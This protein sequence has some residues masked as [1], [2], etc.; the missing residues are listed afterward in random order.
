VANIRKRL[1]DLETRLTDASGFV[2]HSEQWLNYWREILLEGRSGDRT[3]NLPRLPIDAF[4]AIVLGTGPE[5]S[6]TR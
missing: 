3:T 2:P 5:R 4:R 1:Q 6:K